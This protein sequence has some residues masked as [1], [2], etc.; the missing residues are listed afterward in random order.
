VSR[1]PGVVA[2]V[3]SAWLSGLVVAARPLGFERPLAPRHPEA[4]MPR[5]APPPR[6]C[7]PRFAESGCDI[8]EDLTLDES[9]ELDALVRE[10]GVAIGRWQREQRPAVLTARYWRARWPWFALA[11]TALGAALLALALRASRPG[12]GATGA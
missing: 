1:T 9:A 6:F 5:F 11:W 7:E 10:H 12:A 8:R 3:L 4:T 2:L